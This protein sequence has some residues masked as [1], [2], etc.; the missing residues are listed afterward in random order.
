VLI[1]AIISVI[2]TCTLGALFF[3]NAL[4]Q[5][6]YGKVKP[7]LIP[8]APG[9][10]DV[11]MVILLSIIASGLIAYKMLKKTL[12]DFNFFADASLWKS[13]KSASNRFE[14]D[15]DQQPEPVNDAVNTALQE[16]NRRL[17][18]KFAALSASINTEQK[19]NDLLLNLLKAEDD[20]KES[21]KQEFLSLFSRYLKADFSGIYTLDRQS[22]TYS[23]RLSWDNQPQFARHSDKIL[24]LSPDQY[25]WAFKTLQTGKAFSFKSAMLDGLMK[26]ADAADEAA[27]A[28]LQMKVDETAEYLLCKHEAWQFM[29]TMPC[30]VAGDLS[31][32][33]LFGYQQSEQPVDTDVI[34]RMLPVSSVLTKSI[35]RTGSPTVGVSNPG[36]DALYAGIRHLAYAV[37][38]TD[39]SGQ[40]LLANPAAT[41]L[42]NLHE[43]ELIAKPFDAAFAMSDL[44]SGNPITSVFH[45]LTATSP[46]RK[47][48]YICKLN[49]VTDKVIKLELSATPILTAEGAVDGYI[50]LMQDVTHRLE[51]ET[52]LLKAQKFE[53][54]SYL[55]SGLAHDFNN[56]LTA[57]LGNL[58]LAM[59]E[60]PAGSET[61]KLLK[62]AE[63]TT[64]RGTGITNQLL[65]LAK[66]STPQHT[67]SETKANLIQTIDSLLADHKAR[68]RYFIEDD[69]PYI[70][71]AQD[72][73]N[74]VISNLMM[75]AMQAMPTGGEVVVR[76]QS[77]AS[78]QDADLP[79]KPGK[80]VCIHIIDSGEGIPYENQTNIFNPY[81]TTRPGNSGMGLTSVYSILKKYSGHIR[82]HSQM[83]KGT[84]C[85][86]YIPATDT[87]VRSIEIP[88]P[89]SRTTVIDLPVEEVQT[90]KPGVIIL[91]DEDMLRNLLVKTLEKMQLDVQT[92][93]DPDEMLALYDHAQKS[94]LPV[95]MVI[96]DFNVPNVPDFQPYIDKL[97][98]A[99]PNLKLIASRSYIEPGELIDFREMGFDDILS[100]PFHIADLKGMV[101]RN[102]LSAQ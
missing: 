86:I 70:D 78:V 4:V 31:A 66:S 81:F 93:A 84:D 51:A 49:H 23:K 26:Q 67:A 8:T 50:I 82:I 58:S 59:D 76:A 33:M 102:I 48:S 96:I 75:N 72:A 54:V 80:Y 34:D 17:S 43:A 60:L 41:K 24:S 55:S 10:S 35:L 25:P 94:H 12:L 85:E 64:L 99:D 39:S 98:Q 68:V 7:E 71:M 9:W 21:K 61:V 30:F 20:D 77:L 3:T 89:V 95:S 18:Q 44:S 32:V 97:K 100:K 47:A 27:K 90:Q 40:V 22:N 69:L 14:T 1:I 73:F 79:L 62:A 16:E 46:E 83:G 28:W 5:V 45:T 36:Q 29:L 87:P 88:A 92:T 63:E 2:I 13:L 15:Y 57:I 38:V 101:S 52:E 42:S 56:L 53:A 11:L 37:V 74:T 91:K 65:T 19:L 6:I